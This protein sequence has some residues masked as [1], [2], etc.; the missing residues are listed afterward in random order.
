MV[1]GLHGVKA[2]SSVGHG[3]VGQEQM[4]EVNVNEVLVGVGHGDVLHVKEP[5]TVGS[6]HAHN[7]TVAGPTV[8][9]TVRHGAFHQGQHAV[10]R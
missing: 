3:D 1:D 9:V 8:S 2:G 6:S 5:I 7:S 10:L 4:F